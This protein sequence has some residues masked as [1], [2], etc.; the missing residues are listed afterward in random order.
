M[1]RRKARKKEGFFEGGAKTAFWPTLR[2]E[3]RDGKEDKKRKR[4]ERRE[5]KNREGKRGKEKEN[6]EQRTREG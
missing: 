3:K 1:I 2:S 6:E 4:R 5:K